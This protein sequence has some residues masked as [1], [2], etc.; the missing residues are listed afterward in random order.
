MHALFVP[1]SLVLNLSLHKQA[2]RLFEAKSNAVIS[3]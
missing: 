2:S 3:G 1:D